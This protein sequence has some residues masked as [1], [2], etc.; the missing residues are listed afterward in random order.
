MG[1]RF[2]AHVGEIIALTTVYVLPL[3]AL[4]AITEP[5]LKRWSDASAFP[6][7]W[8]VYGGAKLIICL[9]SAAVSSSLALLLG[10]V[11][12]W[13]DLYVAN[14]MMVVIA[15][16]AACLVR[17]NS[18]MR[19][20]LEARNRQL[21]EQIETESLTLQLHAQDFARAREIQEALMPKRLPQIPGCQLAASCQPARSVGG[22]YYDAIQVS[23]SSVAVAV[24]DVSGKGMGAALLMSNLQAIVRAFA[25]T[26]L[27][28]EE[29]CSKANQLISGNVAPG[30]YITF[31]Y[32]VIET[33]CMRVDY[34][35]AGHNP[36][37]LERR[38]GT[39]ETLDEGG[40]VLGVFPKACYV[41]GMR[42]LHPGDRLVLFTD[43]VTEAANPAGEEFGEQR[44][45][46]LVRNQTGDAEE[47]RSRIMSA[48]D[49]FCGGNFHDDAT[50][51]VMALT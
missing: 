11:S 8:V 25:P 41:R 50:L 14:R 32:A 19:S 27:A 9:A 47:C 49:R 45:I 10:I 26:G 39:V 16:L 42:D 13:Q 15:V 12:T 43:G 2:D 33:A 21:E 35:S 18:T 34:C 22:D 38:D 7:D 6:L 23:E 37:I 3:L 40:P 1:G 48:A 5:M 30:K 31:F 4:Q 36:P 24:G 28:P 51:V 46:D 29:I 20:R 44:L 17:L